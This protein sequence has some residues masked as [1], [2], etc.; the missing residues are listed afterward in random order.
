MKTWEEERIE[1][2][3]S[4]YEDT[5]ADDNFQSRREKIEED[6]RA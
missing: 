4:T 1:A 6:M 3:K 5:Y 2:D